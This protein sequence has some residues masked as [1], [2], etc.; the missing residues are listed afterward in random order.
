MCQFC[1]Q[2]GEGKK[3]Y[4]QAKNYSEDLLKDVKRQKFIRDFTDPKRFEQGVAGL[5]RLD[6]M[7]R[8]LRSLMGRL[9][10]GKMKKLHFGQVVP[11]EDVEKIFGFA[12]AVVR[13]A[14]ICRWQK[15]KQEKR[16]CYGMSIG[17]G[18][19]QFGQ[20]MGSADPS[21]REGPYASGS[22]TLTKEEALAA[23]RQ[24][25]KEG[26]CHT[27]WT[28]VTPFIGGICNCDRADCLAMRSTVTHGVPVMFR[29]EFV[30]RVD[31]DRCTGCRQ[32]LRGCQF[33]ALSFSV[34]RSKVVVDR[35]WCYGCG[36][37]RAFCPKGAITLSG[38]RLDPVANDLW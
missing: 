21:F 20:L 3:W 37:C 31:P 23:F 27:I 28:F 17:P 30:A 24:H 1:L 18:G 35:R 38:R 4:L 29:A 16:Y 33:G 14:C 8:F 32:C 12:N 6:K 7:P 26:L 10:T 2:H 15:F 34:G 19:E 11:I 13:V 22:E 9:V 25:E 5:T 36:V